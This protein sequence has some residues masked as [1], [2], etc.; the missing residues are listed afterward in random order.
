[1]TK[2]Q[3][4][5]DSKDRCVVKFGVFMVVK[6]QV[7]VF[8]VETLCSD[9]RYQCVGETCCLHLQGEEGGSKVLLNTGILL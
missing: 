9:V 5:K 6:I 8:W 3:E 2:G 4:L 7:N 1:M